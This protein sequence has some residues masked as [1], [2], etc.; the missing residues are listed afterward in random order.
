MKNRMEASLA[1][2]QIGVTLL[3]ATA[4]AICGASAKEDIAP[5]L[6]TSL[7][8]SPGLAS[9]LSIAMVVLPLSAV[10]IIV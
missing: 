7:G 5:W 1:I 10:T 6:Q 9:V 2:V 4:A 3:G 8:A